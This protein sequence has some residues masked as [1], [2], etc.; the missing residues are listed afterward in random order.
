MM[1][2]S[3]MLEQGH[4]SALP[5]LTEKAGFIK[6][7]T[8]FDLECEDKDHA[9]LWGFYKGVDFMMNNHHFILSKET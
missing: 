4:I 9:A 5:K 1:K 6:G 3:D 8:S 2:M 7:F